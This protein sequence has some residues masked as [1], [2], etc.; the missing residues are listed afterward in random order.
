MKK[1][2]LKYG[3]IATLLISGLWSCKKDFLDTQYDIYNT[4]RSI[5]TDRATL[6]T[7][8]N[9]FY[10]PLPYGFNAIDG[11]LGAAISDEA[12]Q[13][14]VGSGTQIFNQGTLSPTNIPGDVNN[15]Y[16]NSYEGIRAANFYLNYSK[17]WRALLKLNRDTVT[18]ITNYNRDKVLIGYYRGEAHIARAFY[19]AELIK[20]YGGVPIMDN[21]LD[22]NNVQPVARSTYDQ[23]VNYIVKEIDTYKDSLA[24]NW[25]TS[26]YKDQL[27]RFDKGTAFALKARV[28]LYAASPLNNPT[29]DVNKWIAAAAAARDVITPGLGYSLYTGG[30]QTYFQANNSIMSSNPET[31][32]AVRMPPNTYPETN[33][34]PIGTPGGK[35][36]IA[37]SQ[38][39]VS[40]YEYKGTPDAANPYANR[41]PRLA[42]TVVTNGS[43]WNSRTIDI[44]AGG[45]D[46]R[47]KANTSPTGYYLKK[48]LTDNLNIVNGVAATHSWILFRY[49][50][51]LLN[52]AEAMNEAY[53][54]DVIPAGYTLSARQALNLIRARTGVAMPA[55]TVTGVADFRNA[56]KHER[57]IELAFEGHRYFDLLRWK[58]AATV[59]NQPIQGIAATKTGAV[60]SYQT[61]NVATRVFNAPTNYLYPFSQGEIVNS[62]GKL[63]Q[64]PGY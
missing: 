12:Q 7:F 32:M 4:P 23:V 28:L 61:I 18:D 39:L 52:Y 49:A 1:T 9:T 43:T 34:Y 58:D 29:N 33:N 21:L 57:R 60:F 42:A 51:V 35:S 45:T 59:L 2:K 10:L 16:N 3:F 54:P 40:D 56:V 25:S 11:N 15:E 6:T 55:V 31:I 62:G 5:A 27:G 20:R 46:D 64:N 24:V 63:V 41:D 53:G 8:A 26:A 44:S 17:N 36:G 48:Y 22:Y 47:S 19:Y 37:P 50:E 13:T 30:Y 14:V 38:N